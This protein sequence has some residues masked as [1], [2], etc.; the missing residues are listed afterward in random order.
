MLGFKEVESVKL[1]RQFED[2][3]AKSESLERE[4]NVMKEAMQAEIDQLKNGE[5]HLMSDHV[6]GEE[7]SHNQTMADTEQLKE[8][9]KI[10]EGLLQLREQELQ[11]FT[12]TSRG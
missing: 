7:C 4:V 8:K 3:V 12:G 1:K 2:S 11:L 10:A 9:L 6:S 5:N